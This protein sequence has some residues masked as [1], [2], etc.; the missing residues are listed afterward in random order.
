MALQIPPDGVTMAPVLTVLPAGTLLWRLHSDRYGPA[1]FNPRLAH[2]YFKGNRFDA[3]EP[4]GYPYLY[5]ALEPVAALAE[6]FLRSREFENRTAVRMIPWAQASRYRLSAVR[7][8]ADV[9]LVDLTTAEGL[10]AVWQDEWLVDCEER[11]Y[12]KTRYWVQLIRRHSAA[13]QGL[14]WT[15]KRCRPRRALQLFGDRCAPGTLVRIPEE[16]YRLESAT[17]LKEVNRLLEPLRAQVSVPEGL[18]G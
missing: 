14:C 7:T 10:A 9:T 1:E 4:D 5:A 18:G 2:G 12:D 13:A 3:M 8:A 6:V 15:S 16:S 17:D 11:E